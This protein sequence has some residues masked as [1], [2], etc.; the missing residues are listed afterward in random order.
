MITGGSAVGVG[1]IMMF[2]GYIQDTKYPWSG[3][4]VSLSPLNV[5]G[6]LIIITGLCF[7]ASGYLFYLNYKKHTI[8]PYNKSW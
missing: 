2:E 3:P 6:V 4:S 7:L 5:F 8:S 1:G